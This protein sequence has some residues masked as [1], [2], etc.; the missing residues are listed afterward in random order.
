MKREMTC[1]KRT[2]DLFTIGKRLI[3]RLEMT[4]LAL[5]NDLFTSHQ[6]YFRLGSERRQV[7]RIYRSG[8]RYQGD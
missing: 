7:P 5:V 3:E 8:S 6:G 1:L 4:Y 2:N